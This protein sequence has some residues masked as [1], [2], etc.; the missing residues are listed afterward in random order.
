MYY[1]HVYIVYIQS[2]HICQHP[3]V[4]WLSE[5]FGWLMIIW[6]CDYAC[7]AISILIVMVKNSIKVVQ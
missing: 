7:N 6:I 2:T 5:V 4:M 3:S 1:V